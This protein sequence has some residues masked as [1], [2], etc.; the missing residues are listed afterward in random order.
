MLYHAGCIIILRHF[1]QKGA[2]ATDPLAV[3]TLISEGLILVDK[4]T[5]VTGRWSGK[6]KIPS[7]VA[8]KEGIV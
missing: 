6:E 3:L 5:E 2:N 4:F 7:V 1:K 8:R